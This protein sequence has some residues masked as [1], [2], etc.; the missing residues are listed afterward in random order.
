MKYCLSK[1]KKKQFSVIPCCMKFSRE[2]NFADFESRGNKLSRIWIS[3]FT[4]GLGIIFL[5]ISCTIIENNKTETHVMVYSNAIKSIKSFWQKLV[6]LWNS[7]L[8]K[9]AKISSTK[10]LCHKVLLICN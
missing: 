3:D 6:L 1:L 2:F 8:A 5:R 7:I 4:P 10:I 9:F